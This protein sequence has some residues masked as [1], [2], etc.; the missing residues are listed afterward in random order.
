MYLTYTVFNNKWFKRFRLLVISVNIKEYSGVI[1]TFVYCMCP[2]VVCMWVRRISSIWHWHCMASL[3]TFMHCLNCNN[4]N[5]RLFFIYLRNYY[6][7]Q[8]T[9]QT[10][11]SYWF[12]AK[13]PIA[14]AVGTKIWLHWRWNPQ[15]FTDGLSPLSTMLWICIIQ[16]IKSGL[17]I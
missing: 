7:V 3:S 14:P 11:K 10:P 16:K 12:T 1:N 13:G 5:F 6:R 4:P 15:S 17:N 9:A 8:P 2:G